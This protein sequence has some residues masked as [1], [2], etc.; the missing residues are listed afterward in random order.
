MQVLVIGGSGFIGTVL[1]RVLTEAGHTVTIFDK[2]IDPAS[3]YRTIRGDVRDGAAV[4]TAMA[5]QEVVYNLAAEHRDDVRPL[6][7]YD[8]VNVDGARRVC[9]A[10][11]AAGIGALVF[12]SSV[13]VYGAN[14]QPMNEGFPHRPIN[15]YGRTKSLAEDVYKAWL[16]EDAARSLVIVRPTVVFGP[17]NRGNVYTLLATI[18]SGLFLMVGDGRNKKS[19]AFVENI[20]A[21]LAYVLTPQPGLRVFNYS[22]GPDFDMNGLVTEIRSIVRGAKGTGPRLPFGLAM[23]L[24]RTADVVADITRRRLPLSA[25]RVEKF[26]ANTQVDAARAHGSGFTAPHDLAGALRMTIAEEFGSR[27]G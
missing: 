24:G 27:R 1:S 18:N 21:F 4:Q 15:D 20:A 3:P 7:L 14:D 10:A 5:G 12:T 23:A 13:A 8:E 11:T 9:E 16:A 25:V 2:R 17:G 26:V 6:S 19:M 22:D